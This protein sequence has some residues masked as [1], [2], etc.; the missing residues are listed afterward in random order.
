[1]RHITLGSGSFQTGQP[2]TLNEDYVPCYSSGTR[3]RG[4]IKVTLPLGSWGTG[5]GW[6]CKASCWPSIGSSGSVSGT[7][8]GCALVNPALQMRAPKRALRCQGSVVGLQCRDGVAT[9][10]EAPGWQ[11]VSSN[12][13][14]QCGTALSNLTCLNATLP[15]ALRLEAFICYK[16]S[17]HSCTKLSALRPF[18]QGM[19]AQ[20]CEMC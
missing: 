11:D 18:I 4:D 12:G 1:V 14:Q 3:G 17:D 9:A 19:K 20:G 7:S 6:H 2:N 16:T 5:Y 15:K 10:I 13:Y 8:E